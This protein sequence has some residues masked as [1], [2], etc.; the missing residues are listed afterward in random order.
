M[1]FK[2]QTMVT[3]AELEK[4]PV[5]EL[6][7]GDKLGRSDLRQAL[8]QHAAWL[9]S[10]GEAGARA[11]FTG[12]KLEGA[13]LVDARLAGS[14]LLKTNL[15][16]AD[17]TLADLQNATLVQAN[18]SATTLLGT[19]FEQA[20]LQATD[21]REAS[22]LL[23]VQLAGTNLFGAMLPE[24][25]SPLAWLKLVRQVARKAEWLMVVMGLLN[26]VM[27]LRIFTT[28][29]VLLVKN[30]S[31][32]PLPAPQTA[33]PFIPFY[34]FGPVLILCLY[35]VLH[36]Y[37]QRLWDGIAQ[38]PAI[39][40][41]GRKLDASLPWFARWATRRHFHWLKESQSPLAFLE[42]A[43]AILMLYWVV[44]V[45]LILFWGR[46]ITLEDLRGT[47]LHIFLVVGAVVAAVNFPRMARKAFE[48]G[49]PRT[50]SAATP[51][52]KFRSRV[53]TAL[54]PAT[55]VLLLLLSFGTIL[56]APHDFRAAAKPRDVDF[57][58]WAADVLWTAGYNPF[59][60]LIEADVSTKPLGWTG[61]DEEVAQVRG[62]NLNRLRLRYIQGYGAFFVKA[63]LWQADL[64]NAFLTE[65]DLR[66]AN[67]RQADLRN[68]I[69]DRARLTRAALPEANL[70]STNLDRS[71]LRETNLSFAVLADATL[72]DANLDGANLYK[73]DAH[74]ASLQ[75]ATLRKTDLREAILEAA[76]LVSA[77][78]SQSYLVSTNLRGA[79]LNNADLSAAILTDASLRNADL[80]GA[81][82]HGSVLGGA[83]FGGANLQNADLRGAEALTAIQICSASSLRG[84]QLDDSLQQQIAALC[85]NL[86]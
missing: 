7:L 86:R 6:K 40:P 59:A 28:P 9:D 5:S 50:S 63:R 13:D 84:A 35:L 27:W 23:S 51:L 8:D 47:T 37:M 24:A 73:V 55:G 85:G 19:K 49:T 74:G 14:V 43:F 32:L 16:G 65:A 20:N 71:D 81:V 12:R 45:T 39:F 69:L 54:P 18:L 26:G 56:G 10:A 75:R 68:A 21:L 41:D 44:P 80:S 4:P 31:A 11:D 17:L 83:D 77:N 62:A 52:A 46:Y 30:A 15:R 33:L 2:V 48:L 76:N 29:D 53:R 78:L 36:L 79:R 82:L 22:G 1:R 3:P 72:L 66:E 57:K 42:A 34:L 61:R 67:L 25:V 70:A 64:R 38:L 58:E 60:Q